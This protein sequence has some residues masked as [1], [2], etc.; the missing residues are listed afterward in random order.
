[1]PEVALPLLPRSGQSEGRCAAGATQIWSE[2]SYRCSLVFFF[3][4]V[5]LN[6]LKLCI[7]PGACDVVSHSPRHCWNWNL[8]AEESP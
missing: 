5:S 7:I 4:C 8:P 3:F 2:E 6:W 1:M